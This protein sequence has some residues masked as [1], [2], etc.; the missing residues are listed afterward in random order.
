MDDD[1]HGRVEDYTNAFLA[2]FYL[3]LVMALVLI[4]GVWGYLVAL[5][6]CAALHWAIRTLGLRRARA[7]AERDARVAAILAR[8]R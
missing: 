4:W 1:R 8:R 7:E 6:L 2:T 3:I 5:G